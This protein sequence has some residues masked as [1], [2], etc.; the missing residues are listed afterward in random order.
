[1]SAEFIN[2]TP[3]DIVIVDDEKKVVRKYETCDREVRLHAAEQKPM[4]F[5]TLGVPVVSRQVFDGVLWPAVDRH[6]EDGSWLLVSMP[7]GEYIAANPEACRHWVFGPDTGPGA[8][9]RDQRGQIIGTKRLVF[10][11]A[12]HNTMYTC[13]ICGDHFYDR[14]HC[15]RCGEHITSEMLHVANT[16][17]VVRG[18][19][20]VREFVAHPAAKLRKTD[21][22]GTSVASEKTPQ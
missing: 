21:A 7:V 15:P 12:P 2:C 22:D 11:C 4:P 14:G 20:L 1:M 17:L 8:V 9:V 13:P 6:I 18:R 19:A 16:D 10:Y 5:Q 3:H